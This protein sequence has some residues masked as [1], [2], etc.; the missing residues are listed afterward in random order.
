MT[1]IMNPQS[2]DELIARVQATAGSSSLPDDS[3]ITPLKP[4]AQYLPQYGGRHSLNSA[5]LACFLQRIKGKV[6]HDAHWY[7]LLSPHEFI[8]QAYTQGFRRDADATGQKDL[9]QRLSSGGSYLAALHSMSRSSEGL[10]CSPPWQFSRLDKL[11]L[12][13]SRVAARLG[14]STFVRPI[15]RHYEAYCRHHQLLDLVMSIP[16]LM[17]DAL[18]PLQQT[19]R[20]LAQVETSLLAM[21]RTNDLEASLQAGVNEAE[22]SAYYVAFEDANRGSHEAITAKLAPYSDWAEALAKRVSPHPVLDIGCGRGEWLLWLQERGVRATGVDLNADMVAICQEQGL[23]AEQ[24]HALAVLSNQPNASLAAI[25]AFHVIEHVAF[26]YLYAL[27]AESMRCLQPGG[28]VLFETPNPENLLVGSHTFYH[29]FTHRNPITP[30][31]ITFLLSFH[32][33]ERIEI[34]RLNP[35]PAEAKVPGDDP[36]T[37]RVNGHLCG[38]QDFAII[39]YRPK[40][41]AQ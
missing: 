19:Q 4:S 33:F 37:A 31:A 30:S 21:A 10:Q 25:T 40:S 7:L 28:S 35:Y 17:N 32:G 2:L 22:L 26:P 1:I 8:E 20:Q 41:S 38:P 27:V 15:F 39:A 14:L 3:A 16:T 18:A 11:L 9:Q 29:D 13:F 23:L 12:N 36:L 6:S 5:G 24:G 34:R